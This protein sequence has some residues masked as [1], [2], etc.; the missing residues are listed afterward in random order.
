MATV[1]EACDISDVS[2]IYVL[3][4]V[5]LGAVIS[6][7]FRLFHLVR[8]IGS[9]RICE[10]GSQKWC[11][12]E[13]MMLNLRQ[14]C[15]HY[16]PL[17]WKCWSNSFDV[18]ARKYIYRKSGTNVIYPG[19][20]TTTLNIADRYYHQRSLIRI[21]LRINVPIIGRNGARIRMISKNL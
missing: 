17:R 15:Q 21:G 16:H 13:E 18:E 6:S 12:L 9:G 4:S 19:G 14:D 3:D 11:T 20:N 10:C 1:Y 8:H 2:D 5:R 7:G